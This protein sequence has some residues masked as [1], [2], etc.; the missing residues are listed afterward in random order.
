MPGAFQDPAPDR[1]GRNLINKQHAASSGGR[2]RDLNEVDYLSR[3]SDRTR[4][5]A[6]RFALPGQTTFIDPDDRVPELI[7]LP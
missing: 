2:S 7:H 6:L 5:G 4:Q 1:W 3:V